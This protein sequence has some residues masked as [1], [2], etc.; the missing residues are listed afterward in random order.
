M[1]RLT[2]ADLDYMVF[3]DRIF[4]I[5][6]IVSVFFI[7]I[8]VSLLI[9][10]GDPHYILISV[11][12]VIS[13]IALLIVVYNASLELA[14]S[15]HNKS[16][17]FVEAD[18]S[19]ITPSNYMWLFTNF[20]FLALL[21]LSCLW[22]GELGNSD[23]GSLRYMAGILILIGGLILTCHSLNPSIS[24]MIPYLISIGYV[25]LWFGMTLYVVL[26]S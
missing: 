7:I 14:P 3:T 5:Y 15:R 13:I 1:S 25:I 4:W 9:S 22:A 16:I 6:F 17:C 19:C 18:V 21:I 24:N 12:W 2:Y 8:G 10:S 26:K 11:L 20:L 23:S